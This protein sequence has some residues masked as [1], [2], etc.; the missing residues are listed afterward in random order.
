MKNRLTTDNPQG[1]FETMMNFAYAKDRRVVLRFGLGQENIDLC[2]YIAKASQSDCGLD[3]EA[4]MEGA[5]L[6]CDNEYCPLGILYAVATQAAE[7][8]ARLKEYEDSEKKTKAWIVGEKDEFCKTV[9]FAKSR[10]EARVAAMSTDCCED[11]EYTRIEA[12]RFPI[13]D[14]QYKGRN[15]MDWNDPEDRL[16]LVKEGD[17]RCEYVKP[18]CCAKCS[19]KE[20]C[21]TYQDSIQELEEEIAD[22]AIM[23]KQVLM[24]Y[25]CG[26]DTQEQ[27]D[28]KIDRLGRRLCGHKE[29]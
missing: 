2:D 27:V 9:V 15:E 26:D 18:V 11:V 28:F 24:M 29:E 17:F 7:L 23:L 16:F 6:E 20:Y 3:P 13:A 10:N 8:R 22:V 5:C 25:D 4:V 21:N 14:S 12:R 1:N 19:A